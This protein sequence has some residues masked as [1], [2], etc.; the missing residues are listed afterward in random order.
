MHKYLNTNGIYII[1][2][3]KFHEIPRFAALKINEISCEIIKIH[4]GEG[5]WDGF[6]AY[7]KI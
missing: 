2:D 4:Q 7:K 3:I 6:I 1:E 5:Y